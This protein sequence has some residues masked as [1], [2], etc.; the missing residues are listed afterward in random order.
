SGFVYVVCQWA[1]WAAGGVAVPLCTSHPLPEQVYSLTDS[2]STL[3]LVHPV[4]QERQISLVAETKITT[5][6]ISD[7]D[8]DSTC[9]QTLPTL[10]DMDNQR[11]ALIVFTSGTTGKPKGAVSTHDNIDAQ[12]SVL[13]SEWKWTQQDRIHHI[14]PLHHVHGII[15]ALT[16]P[17]YA[18]ATVE[19][20]EKFDAGKTWQRWLNTYALD[21]APLTV[22]M[23]VP[24]V[25]SKLIATYK[26]LGDAKRQASYGKACKQFRFMVSGSASLPTPLRDAWFQISDQVLLE[27]YGMTELGMA[28]SQAYDDRME[29]TVGFPLPGV[30]VRLMA[31]TQ[32]GSGIYNKNVTDCRDIPGQVQVKGRNV[33]KEYWQR[34]EATA[35]EF[36]DGWFI[37]GDFAMRVQE[38]GY[39]QI[40]G[41]GSIDILKTGGEKVSALEIERELLSCSLGILDVA[42]IGVPDPEWGQRVAAV[43]VM[44]AKNKVFK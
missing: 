3:L 23:T 5:I 10:F 19:M 17:L 28:F 41:R 12:T 40:L 1:I 15:N 37:T 26:A 32:E 20:H 35:K 11:R 18:G 39:Y 4:F 34:P 33:F 43:V 22:F 2:Q 24:T 16:C 38:K 14:L 13:V 36:T 27:R 31:E 6:M 30:Q 21:M 8:I 7:Q 9:D 42:V 44:E 29:G 25:Y